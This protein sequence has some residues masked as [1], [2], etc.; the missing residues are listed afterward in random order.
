MPGPFERKERIDWGRKKDGS[1]RL[2][3]IAKFC[4]RILA[5]DRVRGKEST[6]LGNNVPVLDVQGRSIV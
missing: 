6:I 5:C 3:I 1:W 2:S 4:T